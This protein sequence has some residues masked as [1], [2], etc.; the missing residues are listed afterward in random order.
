MRDE[1]NAFEKIFGHFAKRL[2]DAPGAAR[3]ARLA[4]TAKRI[5]EPL[6]DDLAA[7][8][9]Q[10]D[11]VQLVDGDVALNLIEV[12]FCDVRYTD[13]VAFASALKTRLQGYVDD[14]RVASNARG[15]FRDRVAWWHMALSRAAELCRWPAFLLMEK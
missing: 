14:P 4:Q 9:L 3:L 2:H 8:I 12:G 13:A 7:L 1:P 5:P 6:L 11:D 10:L 15:D